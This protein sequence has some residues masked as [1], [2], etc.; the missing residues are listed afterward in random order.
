[1]NGKSKKFAIISVSDKK[2]I[3]KIANELVKNGYNI[4]STGGTAKFLTSKN[5]PNVSISKFTKFDE[6]LEGRV[7]TLHPIIHAGILAKD[8][9]SLKNIKNTSYSLIDMVVVNLYPFEQIISKKNCKFNDAIENIDIGGPTMLRAAAKNHNRVT[10]VTDPNDY[11]TVISELK[12]KGSTTKNLRYKLALKVFSLISKYDS[13]ITNYLIENSKTKEDLMPTELNVV[14]EK[15]NNLRYGENPHQNAALYNIKTPKSLGF[16]FKQLAGKELS[17]NNLVDSESASSCV[18]QFQ[19]HACVIVKHA[20][21]CGVSEST[22]LLKAYNEAYTTDPTSAFG[23]IIAFNKKLDHKLLIKILSQ[24][25]VEV[26]IAPGVTKECLSVIKTKPNVRLIVIKDFL[27]NVKHIEMK[28][29]K[30]KFLIQESDTKII[31]KKDLK[32]V[33]KKKPS[34]AQIDDLLFA[35]KVARYVKSNAIVF[36]K[37]KRTLGIGAGQ[38]SRIDSTNI[39]HSKAKKFNISLKNCVMASEA[40]FPFRDNVDLA[41]KIGVSSIIQP[42]GSVKDKE[43]ISISDKHKI[44]MVFSGVRVFKH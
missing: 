37:N 9:K 15:E 14:L 30:N 40:F 4:L 31:S 20:N 10:V 32:I 6:I 7:K 27:K 13:V 36:V 16:T 5:I 17:F 23:G 28:S 33:T 38:M 2:N 25:F 1:M 8:E 18:K 21:P 19:K 26:I 22:S 11:Q 43:I 35:F 24:Q 44:S 12:S 3:D 39:A 34:S 42:G 41:K 29:L